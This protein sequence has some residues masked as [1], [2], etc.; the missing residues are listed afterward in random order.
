MSSIPSYAD[1]EK[2]VER[3]RG[4]V[5]KTPLLESELLN[6]RVGGRILIK[7]EVLQKTGSFKVRGATNKVKSIIEQK[8]PTRL[9]AF[10]SGNHAQ[11]IAVT[12]KKFGIPVT[13]VMPETAPPIKIQNTK[14][15][16]AEIIFYNPRL[17]NREQMAV[18]LLQEQGSVLVKPYDDPVVIA[19]QGTV[20]YEIVQ[21]TQELGID[22]CAVVA[23]CGGGGLVSGIAL[24]VK[25]HRPNARVWAVEPEYYNDTQRSLKSGK[26]ENNE[27]SAPASI[28]D[29]IITPTPGEITFRINARYLEGVVCVSD[30][31]VKNAMKSAFNTYKLV[32][33]PGGCVGLAA[34]LSGKIDIKGR[35][36][37]VIL[38]GGNADSALYAHI[39]EEM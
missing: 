8:K 15:Y 37:V 38:S 23:P 31:E 6:E 4:H 39:L 34:V 27:H 5:I 32:V 7:A 33:E 24:A 11:A 26:R 30:N 14:A 1:I 36:V 13:V 21:Q 9:I 20:G 2:A 10:S 17:D 12:A 18:Q 16:G 19:G 29:S 28:C 35:T 3:I 25:H 22:D